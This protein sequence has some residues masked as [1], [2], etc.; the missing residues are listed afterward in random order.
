MRRIIIAATAVALLAA[1]GVAYAA[2]AVNTYT[3]VLTFTGAAGTAAKPAP[4]GFNEKLT[5]ANVNTSL[6]AVPL[7][8]ITLTMDNLKVDYKPFPVCS[9]NTI[10]TTKNDTACPKGSLV[11]TGPISASI[12]GTTLNPAEELAPAIRC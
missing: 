5:A 7:N 6:L 4:V 11:A 9:I 2:T 12:G 8:K 10:N 3:G 1:A